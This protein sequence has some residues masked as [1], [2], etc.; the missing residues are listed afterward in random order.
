MR[1]AAIWIPANIAEGFRRRAKADKVRLRNVAE[2][3]TEETRYYLILAHDLS[4]G[5]TA[6]LLSFCSTLVP[7]DSKGEAL[8]YP[9][10]SRNL[11]RGAF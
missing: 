8:A 1:R 2:G 7:R 10:L 4:D 5:E 11:C 9:A 3:S 6:M